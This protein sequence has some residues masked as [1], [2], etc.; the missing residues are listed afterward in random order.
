METVAIVVMSE[1]KQVVELPKVLENYSK[2]HRQ[3]RR[4][5]MMYFYGATALTLISARLAYR[6]VQMRK[7]E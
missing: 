4:K 5:Q 7:C 6:G 1:T 2:E 3:R